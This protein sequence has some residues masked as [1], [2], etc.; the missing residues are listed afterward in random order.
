[1]L[2]H[3]KVFHV[4]LILLFL[5]KLY[6]GTGQYEFQLLGNCGGHGIIK[7]NDNAD[8]WP[9]LCNGNGSAWD[10]LAARQICLQL[11]YRDAVSAVC[12]ADREPLLDSSCWERNQSSLP[13]WCS[14]TNESVCNSTSTA[15]VSCTRELC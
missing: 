6:F 10:R 11:G 14:F 7:I 15:I 1:M 3:P 13:E 4:V 12:C 2:D 8:Q 5:L 9:D